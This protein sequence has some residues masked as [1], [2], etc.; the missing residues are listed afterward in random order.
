MQNA[1][2]H[3]TIGGRAV[4]GLAYS[5]PNLSGSLIGS[6]SAAG[7][8]VTTHNYFNDRTSSIDAH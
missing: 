3:H 7:E 8:T 1:C 5:H 2:M 4:V 6:S